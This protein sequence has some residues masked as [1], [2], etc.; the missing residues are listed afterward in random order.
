MVFGK[1]PPP[2]YDRL[3]TTTNAGAVPESAY[4]IAT[5]STLQ[6]IPNA[7]WTDVLFN[8]NEADELGFHSTTTNTQRM[9][10]PANR[11]GLYLVVANVEFDASTAGARFYRLLKNGTR[12]LELVTG[13]GIAFGTATHLVA[14]HRLVAADYLV[15]QVYQ[16]TGAAL[17]LL[18]NDE[19]NNTVCWYRLA[20]VRS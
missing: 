20:R 4:A 19:V 8:T 17:N 3:A 13:P 12:Q 5:N 15:V 16:T 2:R 6:S 9:T 10:V 11:D 7:A 14:L 18:A 1:F